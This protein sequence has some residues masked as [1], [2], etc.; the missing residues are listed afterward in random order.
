MKTALPRKTNSCDAFIILNKLEFEKKAECRW[1][2][3]A[4]L[5]PGTECRWNY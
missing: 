5:V 3:K 4:T 1:N 2:H